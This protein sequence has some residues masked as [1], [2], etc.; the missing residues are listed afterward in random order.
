MNLSIEICVCVHMRV[1]VRSTKFSH[2]ANKNGCE[3][4]CLF[5]YHKADMNCQRTVV[6]VIIGFETMVFSHRR[7]LHDYR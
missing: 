4:S 5:D 7:L 2:T 3:I 1:Y 6:E